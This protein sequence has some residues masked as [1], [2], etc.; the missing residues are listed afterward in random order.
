M[1]VT[2]FIL[3]FL[4][5]W[6]NQAIANEKVIIRVGHFATITH[7]QGVLGHAFARRGEGWFEKRL[8]PNVE[9][10]W[11]VYDAG[12]GAM[13]GIFID[14]IDLAYVGPSP[15]INAYIKS[16]GSVLRIVCGSCS[17]G[18]ALVVQEDG[19]INND[20]D[21]KGKKIGTP[22]F[23]GTQDIM[24]RSW[25]QSIGFHVTTSGGDLKVIP[26]QN[27]DQRLLFQKK[28]LDA[29]WGIE[30]WV[31]DLILEAN[32]KI[33]LNESTLWP[34]TNGQYV[35]AHLVSST[36]FLKKHTELL[37]KWVA[38]HMELTNWINEHP[39]E[40]KVLLRA[41]IKAEVK[42]E[43]NQRVFER[44]WQN[45]TF[46]NDPIALSL[47]TYAENAF[48]IGFLK[49]KPD[50]TGIYDLRFMQGILKK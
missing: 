34:Q 38:A 29:V 47:H 25:L 50:L 37:Q 48:R 27:S 4:S 49:Q 23:G 3:I 30:P 14:S 33:Y 21:F 32:G 1:I 9:V 18:S 39:K 16:K 36:R 43:L 35:T 24:A 20:A 5:L 41:E 44:A 12:P 15:T 31:S 19:G 22:A 17:G 8:G 11:Y 45:L 40:A 26:T 7:A 46:T 28:E 13:E 6:A 10:H 42:Q 2:R